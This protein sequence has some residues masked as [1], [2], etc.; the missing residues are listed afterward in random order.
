MESSEERQT[1]SKMNRMC[2]ILRR[3]QNKWVGSIKG[4]N[5]MNSRD[6]CPIKKGST[7]VV[8]QRISNDGQ[9]LKNSHK[10]FRN[11]G[12]LGSND[13]ESA[14]KTFHEE[15]RLF[16]TLLRSIFFIAVSFTRIYRY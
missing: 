6:Y 4:R 15:G 9:R 1:L 8:V 10:D 5:F 16:I 7:H 2:R 12:V 14:G 13:S 3:N 11:C